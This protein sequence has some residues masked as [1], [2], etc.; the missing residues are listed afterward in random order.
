MTRTE[1]NWIQT[2]SGRQ[3]WPL[4]PKP[5]DVDV[6]DI[7]H[8]LALKCRFAGHCKA[9]YSV[10]QHSVLV[11]TVV[12]EEEALWGLL[13]D[14]AEAYLADLPRPVKAETP[15]FRDAEGR[16]MR[17]VAERFGLAW[18]EPEGVKLADAVLLVTEQRDLMGPPPAPW[19]AS[20]PAE[21]MA[22]KVEPV[23]WR[24]AER[25][26]LARF[27]ELT[28]GRPAPDPV[29]CDRCGT[30]GTAETFANWSWVDEDG[31]RYERF[32]CPACECRAESDAYD[33]IP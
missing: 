3:F 26:F 21:P 5:G 31:E 10:A 19:F 33:S 24:A 12:P 14:A 20:R 6:A 30:E 16:I 9:F 11:S 7:A 25:L 2:F 23:D 1:S 32:L 15:A 22:G 28:T 4:D 8:A 29:L 13:H 27:E 17:A 18:P